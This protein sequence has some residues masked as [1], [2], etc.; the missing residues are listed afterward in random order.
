MFFFECIWVNKFFFVLLVLLFFSSSESSDKLDNIKSFI[1]DNC[2][3]NCKVSFIKFFLIEFLL[4][5][6]ISK[7]LELCCVAR[8]VNN[9]GFIC[10]L[11]WRR[12]NNFCLFNFFK[13]FIL[14]SAFISSKKLIWLFLFWFS[15]LGMLV[16]FIFFSS[17]NFINSFI[18]LILLSL[19]YLSVLSFEISINCAFILFFKFIIFV[20]SALIFPI[21]KSSFW[22]WVNVLFIFWSFGFSFNLLLLLSKFSVCLNVD[23]KFNFLSSFLFPSLNKIFVNVFD[24]LILFVETFDL[25]NSILFFFNNSSISFWCLLTSLH[26]FF[27]S[28]FIRNFSEYNSSGL[29]FA[30]I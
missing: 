23:L 9:L 25:S 17:L 15:F 10:F 26:N 28:F 1:Q 16:F 8:V 30:I 29:L 7:F 20:K 24:L 27:S 2:L 19:K 13:S 4:R 14:F 5:K 3:F 18:L 11:F 6:K 12:L 22:F 21:F